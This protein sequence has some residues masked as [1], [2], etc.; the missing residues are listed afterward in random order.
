MFEMAPI[1]VPDRGTRALRSSSQC[2][3]VAEDPLKI[4]Q[5]VR[6]EYL[7]L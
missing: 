1:R 4:E 2:R 7:A 3:P 6:K 5:L